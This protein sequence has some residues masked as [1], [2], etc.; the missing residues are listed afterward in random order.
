[1]S[2]WFTVRADLWI[3]YNIENIETILKKGHE[4]GFK[5]VLD[6][7]EISIEKSADYLMRN[8]IS[9]LMVHIESTVFDIGIADDDGFLSIT[10][11]DFG[12]G[13]QKKHEG[14]ITMQHDLHRYAKVLLNLIDDYQ[15]REFTI[16]YV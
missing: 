14:V 4:I 3:D 16:S 11:S 1:M 7:E 8:E 15:I 2:K 6:G 13:W 9:L 5:Y 10:F 12:V